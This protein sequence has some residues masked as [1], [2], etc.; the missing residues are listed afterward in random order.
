[1]GLKLSDAPKGSGTGVI[2]PAG[3]HVAR[4]Y[5][6]VD[7][8]S[9]TEDGTFGINTNRKIRISW[10]LPEELHV[11]KEENGPQPIAVHKE[12]NF[13]VGKKSNLRKDLGSWRG[14]EYTDEEIQHV[15]IE[16]ILGVTALLNIVHVVSQAGNTYAK[17]V[18]VSN[19]PKGLK[20][21]AEVNAP[22]YYDI[23]MGQN[24]VFNSFPEFLRKRILACNEWNGD[25]AIEEEA[26][27]NTTDD[28]FLGG[29]EDNEKPF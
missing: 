7:L 3:S 27:V 6:V 4:C 25:T 19:P 8:G 26:V 13:V 20:I 12:Y 23:E 10:E 5:S 17:I 9:H 22:V 2:A 11:F 18:G 24:E 15:D 16:K 29:P 14:K 21:P 28:N 1:M